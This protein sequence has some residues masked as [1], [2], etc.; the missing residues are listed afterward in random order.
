[1]MK[2][3]PFTKSVL[4]V[5][6]CFVALTTTASVSAENQLELRG[7]HQ[8]GVGLGGFLTSDND[9]EDGFGLLE[10]FGSGLA[11]AL[12]YQYWMS[13]QL[14]IGLQIETLGEQVLDEGTAA[15]Q[16]GIQYKPTSWELSSTSFFA[17]DLGLGGYQ[18]EWRGLNPSRSSR[19]ESKSEM[20][21]GGFAGG[22]VP[23]FV[24]TLRGFRFVS[25]IDGECLSLSQFP[26]AAC[27]VSREA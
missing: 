13:D 24:K 17:V 5:L 4:L 15:Y 26:I 3:H 1:M 21:F 12:R 11:A 10:S 25:S 8:F 16:F 18:R 2:T 20:V 27:H 19:G 23:I 9:I 14:A 7:K 6:A 22:D